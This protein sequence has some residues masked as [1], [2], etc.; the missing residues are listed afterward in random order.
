LKLDA[1]SWR[2]RLGR[3][4]RASQSGRAALHREICE[5]GGKVQPVVIGKIPEFKPILAPPALPPDLVL[6]KK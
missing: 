2:A 4:R 3:F 6:P 1:P 5:A